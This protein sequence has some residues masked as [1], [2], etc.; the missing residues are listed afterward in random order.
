M[1]KGKPALGC[2]SFSEKCYW[3]NYWR[4]IKYICLVQR[5]RTRCSAAE[6]F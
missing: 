3:P 4:N 5:R 6:S 2:I 1:L